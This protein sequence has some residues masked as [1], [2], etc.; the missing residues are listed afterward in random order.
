MFQQ[1][2]AYA[3][4]EDKSVSLVDGSRKVGADGVIDILCNQILAPY[5]VFVYMS[6]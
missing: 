5:N 2:P 1:D 6:F 4:P 3:K